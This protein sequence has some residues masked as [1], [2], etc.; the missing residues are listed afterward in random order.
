MIVFVLDD[1][2]SQGGPT[3]TAGSDH[4]FHTFSSENSDSNWRDCGLDEWIID[5]TSVLF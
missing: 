1:F 5:D 3:F 2:D 4:Y